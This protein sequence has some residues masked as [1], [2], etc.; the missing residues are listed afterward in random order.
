[1]R[2]VQ[3]RQRGAALMSPMKIQSGCGGKV[4]ED[5]L[6][7]GRG[8]RKRG[9]DAPDRPT[10]G[11]QPSGKTGRKTEGAQTTQDQHEPHCQNF[12]SRSRSSPTGPTAA[13]VCVGEIRKKEGVNS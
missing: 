12:A 13:Q 8:R 4:P 11:E 3:D 6:R 5:D 2:R 10:A 9:R 7:R 1:A